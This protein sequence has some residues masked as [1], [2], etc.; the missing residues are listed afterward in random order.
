[1]EIIDENEYEE[2]NEL[3]DLSSESDYKLSNESLKDY[4]FLLIN[5]NGKHGIELDYDFPF[6]TRITNVLGKPELFFS[7]SEIKEFLKRDF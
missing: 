4:S 7:F 3:K 6:D 5:K 1:M 2:R